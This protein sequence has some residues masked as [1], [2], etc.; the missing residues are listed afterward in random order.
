MAYYS[1]NFQT[2]I[3]ILLKCWLLSIL[4]LQKTITEKNLDDLSE[5]IQVLRE[6]V[7][8]NEFNLVKIFVDHDK[9]DT[10]I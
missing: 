10:G 4:L 2:S 8:Y 5:G 1:K 9:L 6:Y 7:F 3:V